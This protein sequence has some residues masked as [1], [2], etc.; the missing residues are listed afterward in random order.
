MTVVKLSPDDLCIASMVAA[1]EKKNLLDKALNLLMQL[2]KD[3]REHGVATLGVLV[4][5]LVKLQ[6]IDEAGQ[7][8]GM[9]AEKGGSL[10]FKSLLSLCDMYSRAGTGAEKKAR[11]APGGVEAEEE[12]LLAPLVFEN[13]IKGLLAGGFVHDAQRVCRVMETQGFAASQPLKV[14]LS[15]SQSFGLNRPVK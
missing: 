1:Y 8:L 10:P 15:V 2:E 11:Q 14:A 3:G 6:L 4:N 13:I 7:V 5:W 12:E 9:I